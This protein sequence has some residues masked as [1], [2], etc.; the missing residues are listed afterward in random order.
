MSDELA[1]PRKAELKRWATIVMDRAKDSPPNALENTHP[2]K[3]AC[4][5][6][7]R[8]QG[9]SYKKI[10]NKYNVGLAT[11][12]RMELGYK[13]PLAEARKTASVDWLCLAD[14]SRQA[15]FTKLERMQDDP[16]L[17][18]QV[19]LDRLTLAA[20]VSQDKAMVL[21]G[22]AS[23]IVEHKSGKSIEEAQEM[24]KM[25]K[26]RVAEKKKIIDVE[27]EEV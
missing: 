18:D 13:E 15:A 24:I 26:A 5:L 16:E 3:A 25:A 8:A 20:A 6:W 2:E 17:L 7:H 23:T 1:D 12:K 4:I 14:A 9:D 27:A 22:Q 21:E 10:R 11:I 19:G